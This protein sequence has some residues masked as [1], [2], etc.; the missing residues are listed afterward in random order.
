MT[1]EE[2]AAVIAR[3]HDAYMRRDAAALAANYA[4]DCVV[5]SPIVGVHVGR[6]EVERVFRIFFAA[7]P[8]V[9]LRSDEFL[10]SGNRAVWT[11]TAT[12]TDT[13][14]FMGLPSTGQP[15]STPIILLYTFGNDHRIVQE[16]RIYDFSRLLL[17]LADGAEP[18]T[19]GP[20]LY[21]ELVERAQREHE[22]K[23]AAEIQRALLPQSRHIGARRN[24]AG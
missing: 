17:R 22:L 6:A 24:S 15:F 13:G 11:V 16:R 21:Q 23:V 9:R 7:F 19:E 20:R 1:T 10:I 14:G 2:I 8:D 12:G 3:H 4:D 5:D 18:A